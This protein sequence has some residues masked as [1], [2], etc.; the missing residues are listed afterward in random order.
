M[1]NPLR[2][3]RRHQKI[4]MVFFGVGLMAVFGL[5]SVVSMVQKQ[6]RVSAGHENPVYAH[7]KGGDIKRSDLDALR[8]RHFQT[9][10]FLQG[11]QSYAADKKGD[12]FQSLAIPI[13]PVA[14][15]Q[16]FQPELVDEEL[17][18]RYLMAL[19]AEE[20][21]LVVGDG[22]VDDYLAL[23]A[24]NVPV[25]K[26][27]M[28][29][30][31]KEVN[32]GQSGLEAIRRQLKIE[33]AAQQMS[34]FAMAGIPMI[35]NPLD[36]IELYT[37]T[38]RRVECQVLPIAVDP[39]SITE[40]PT[41]TEVRHLFD[42]GKNNYPDPEG[43]KPGFKIG[44]RVSVQYFVANRDTFLQNE[45]NKLT[46]AEV[47]AEYERL[48][49]AESPVVMEMIPDDNMPALTD[50]SNPD[51]GDAAPIQGNETKQDGT[52]DEAP[53][54]DG[55][56][57]AATEENDPAPAKPED[58]GDGGLSSI[59]T[60]V[61][62]TYVSTLV[63]EP[64]EP[65]AEE[66]A[67]S[68]GENVGE[69]P[70]EE[71]SNSAAPAEQIDAAKPAEQDAKGA[72][73]ADQSGPPA[74]AE[75]APNK[76]APESAEVDKADQVKEPVLPG[77]K[78]EKQ[79]PAKPK[80]RPKPLIDCAQQVK[81]SLKGEA[82]TQ[83]IDDALKRAEA[84]LGGY[85]M[86]YTRWKFGDERTRGEEPAPVD[87]K[88]IADKYNL[89]FR[90]TGL[91]DE[92]QLEETEIGKTR[93]FRQVMGPNGR[94]QAAFPPLAQIIFDGYH[95]T[96]EYDPKREN[97]MMAGATYLYWLSEKADSRIPNLEDVKDEIVE[98][99]KKQKAFDKALD[100]AR[101][102]ASTVNEKP[103]ET[104]IGKYPEK[105]IQT[106][107]FTWFNTTSNRPSISVPVGVTQPGEDFMKTVFGLDQYQAAAT[108]NY[109]RD[110]VYVVQMM[111][112][113]AS[114]AESGNDYLENRFFKFKTIP[115]DVRSVSQWYGQEIN[116]DWN[117]EFTKSMDLE[118]LG[119]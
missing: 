64:A 113:K 17:L 91:L 70:Q 47:Q 68:V 111:S 38:S 117:E 3:F 20:E 71:T 1:A 116:I 73:A 105:A 27:E 13:R 94:P 100:E 110:T 95:D 60:S 61:N 35:P 118:F 53:K 107:E 39:D 114:V 22:M 69:T 106:G 7:W 5:G 77:L 72:E 48:V 88:A 74:A 21:G 33:L 14:Q 45:I 54:T 43:I 32:S 109:D 24:G 85:R 104:L 51:D 119:Q 8:Y 83:A 80:M 81:E 46:D 82:A 19:K 102:I 108:F 115:N 101:Q 67:N 87:C 41:A 18:S 96:N 98:F 78:A 56:E 9:I 103:G 76:S 97:D 40:Q 50:P 26:A 42:E 57:P 55:G 23:V 62:S 58:Q 44:K 93:V 29:A 11:L 59:V 4:M 90:E 79:E 86:M 16:D 52:T 30:I 49:A 66:I 15:G 89:E 28:A 34:N 63:Q 36:A 31:N 75:P 12:N 37:K 112:A 6:H 25:S 2:W 10:R 65:T 99:W 92:L 84:D